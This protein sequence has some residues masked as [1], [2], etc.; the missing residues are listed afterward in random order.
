MIQR[1]KSTC[2]GLIVRVIDFKE[3]KNKGVP[4]FRYFYFGIIKY[5]YMR[6]RFFI[7]A[8][9]VGAFGLW[10]GLAIPRGNE[11]LYQPIVKRV[12]SVRFD[13][14]NLSYPEDKRIPLGWPVFAVPFEQNHKNPILFFPELKGGGPFFLRL[15]AAI[16]FREEK[17]LIVYLPD[18]G[19]V[20]GEMLMRYAHPFQPFELE[21]SQ[22][23]VKKISIEG[24]GFKIGKG[25][26]D[27]WF[28]GLS[29]DGM[30]PDGLQ[31]HI[32]AGNASNKEAAFFDN[33]YSMNSFSPFGWMGGSVQD[34]LLEWQLLG[35]ERA[36]MALK[37]HLDS[38]LD[39]EVGLRFESPNTRPLDGTFNSLEDFVPIAA[40]AQIY[41]KH[42]SIDLALEFS[43]KNLKADGIITGSNITTE[44]CYTLAYPLMAI[45]ISRNDKHIA[46]V[47]MNQLVSR[48]SY[49]TDEGA[50]YQRSTLDGIKEFRNWGRGVVWYMLG[51]VKT[52]RLLKNSSFDFS[53][54]KEQLTSSFVHLAGVMK[55]HQDEQGMW[56]G[57]VDQPTMAVDTSATAGIAA[58]MCWGIYLGI[59]D[60]TYIQVAEKARDGMMKYISPDG[61]VRM[62][63]QINRGGEELQ[64][65]DYR[66]I[67]Q[68]GMGLLAQLM[69][70]LT[71][72]QAKII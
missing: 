14:S 51:V 69:A 21:I 8:A 72:C 63:S 61:F 2:I 40:I 58:A 18:S 52:L 20:I 29:P 11:T 64:R 67:T 56:L 4:H 49:L 27:A 55:L 45:A 31:P 71:H 43:S 19:K 48:M 39:D 17:S 70:A 62:V 16:D 50:I 65:S 1:P 22:K 36:G 12:L 54:E 33:L 26:G 30:A 60:N 6:R 46:Q 9:S 35:D 24:V 37:L 3:L 66:V 41:P 28:Y 34:A 15:T 42:R 44:G 68:F 53:E 23:M 13:A 47:A 5:Y 59:L 7:E 32:V 10:S 25:T 57:Y 38:Y